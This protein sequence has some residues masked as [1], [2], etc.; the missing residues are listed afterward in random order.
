M[1]FS[2]LSSSTAAMGLLIAFATW[3]ALGFAVVIL[4]SGLK[5]IPR[6][7]YE[8]AWVDGAHR[9]PFDLPLVVVHRESVEAGR[10]LADPPGPVAVEFDD[11]RFSYPS[12][13]KVSLASLE[14]VSTLDTRGGEE[15]LHGISFRV[16]LSSYHVFIKA[17]AH[18]SLFV[19]HMGTVFFDA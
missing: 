11:V 5:S 7:Y 6:D 3:R 14:E 1:A 15:V 16:E 10:L 2:P 18:N 19:W 4:L 13:D 17:H 9:T 12:A 8:A